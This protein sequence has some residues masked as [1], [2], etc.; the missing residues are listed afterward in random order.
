[1]IVSAF[2]SLVWQAAGG[3]PEWLTVI[4]VLILMLILVLIATVAF[5]RWQ[6]R[7][8]L[9]RRLVE[10]TRLAEA[11]KALAGAEL[12]S[13]RLAEL[14]YQQTAQIVDASSFQLGLFEGDRYRILIWVVDGQ[15]RPAAEYSLTTDNL[16][17][18]GWLRDNRRN[19]LVRDFQ[20]EAA[21]L[22]AQ[23]SYESADPPRS[24]V[25]VPL[26]SRGC[27]LGAVAIQSRQPNAF[28]EEDVRLLAIVA[29]QAASA[30]EN[31]QLLA[32]AQRRANQ[33]EL[34]AGVSQRIN[35]LQP[36]SALYKQIVDLVAS[37]F[38]EYAVSYYESQGETL[39]LCVSSPGPGEGPQPLER[40]P[41][42]EGAAGR[43]AQERRAVA[44]PNA[45]APGSQA[46]ETG[47]SSPQLAV[48]VEIDDR[49][50]GVLLVRGPANTVFDDSAQTVFGALA[51]QMAIAILEAQFYAAEQQR[52]DQLGALAQ[53]S[54]TVASSLELDD[55]LDEVLDVL[56]EHF[57]YKSIRIFLLYEDRLV[58]QAGIG[59]GTVGQAVGGLSYPLDGPGL[60][61]LV[62]RSRQP[63]L[64]D[65]VS[66]HPEYVPG[67]GLTST[68]S[69][70]AAP[71]NMGSRL[72]GVLDVQSDRVGAFGPEDAR[73]L[74]ALGD[75]LAVAVRNA[76]LFEYERRRRRLA[77]S[78]RDVSAALTSTL[79]LDHV[80]DLIL[81][82]LALVVSYDASSIL[83]VNDADEMILRASRGAS[84]AEEAIGTAMALK[85]YEPGE[86]VPSV[87]PFRDVDIAH[88]YHDLLSLPEP[89][90]CLAAALAPGGE[91]LGYLVVDKGGQ[92][93]FPQG[94]VELISTFASQ[95]AVAIENA[96]LYT[97][98]REQAWISTALLQVADAT[99]RST[100]LD[101]VL[102]TVARLT[103]LLVGVERCVVL[104]AEDMGWRLAA[105]A[106]ADDSPNLDP[107]QTL[108]QALA[109]EGW[110]RLAELREAREPLVLDPDETMPAGLREWFTGVVILLPLLARGQVAGAI[111]VGQVTGDSPFTAHRIQL[112]TGIA[113]Q[114]ALA[115]EGA[116]LSA[117]QQEEA[118]VSTALLQVAQSV[119]GQPLEIGLET[120][121]RLTPILVGVERV[122]IY[123]Y[124]RV[125]GGFRL[126][127][128][129]GLDREA[130]ARLQGRTIVLADLGLTRDDSLFGSP[131]PWSITLPA[132]L[133]SLFGRNQ[134]GVWPLRARGDTI[135]PG[136]ILG[137]LVT[138]AVPQLGRRQT[139][140]DGIAH[141]LAMALENDRLAY[142]VAQQ[143]RLERELEVGRDIQASLL[144][145][146]YPEA[147]G[148]E[149]A[150][151]WRA[152]RQV[153][154]D[155][156]DFFEL[157]PEQANP[158]WGVVIADVAD[159]G[160]PAALFMALSRTL[161]RSV[162]I[163][164]SAP[165]DTLRRVNELILSDARS[166][167]FVTVAYGVLEPASGRYCYALGGHNPPV[168]VRAD[169]SA[170]IV[171][172]RGIALGVVDHVDYQE[173]EITLCPGDALLLY[174]DG[175]TEAIDLRQQ[176]FG[177]ERV[178]AVARA[179]YQSTARDLLQA[180]TEAVDAHVGEAEVFDDMTI[181]VIKRALEAKE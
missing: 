117:A 137:V 132:P 70:M 78:M 3:R 32:Q 72:L 38:G 73:T 80:L 63:I 107:T 42:G 121:A 145:Q 98:Q 174:T 55:M 25:F 144:P 69:E 45:P 157:L 41:A 135:S 85:R 54:R 115:V 109:A 9:V 66:Q 79:Q 64:A 94:E 81:D 26:L 27:V 103:P 181:V 13:A 128:V 99:A 133:A 47:P 120:A 48:P 100:E 56:D 30:F 65:D 161:L 172:G 101:E 71:L 166:E 138:E 12:D 37:T 123:Q 156:Y 1:M 11:G 165:A 125:I 143:E 23:P 24:A 53:V 162:A 140:L 95:A 6:S 105:Q 91:H 102:D 155:F 40:V 114:A 175:L 31:A 168:W 113:N 163:G 170:A 126:R 141:Q 4:L 34:L 36:L 17:I 167:Q 50:R 92:S 29:N 7:Q 67:P 131:P 111:L 110:P 57:G 136:E 68:R 93:R 108:V 59:Q 77:E 106:T 160:V 118:W 152:A 82:G 44:L 51:A 158:R 159:K 5:R 153:G 151:L 119:A 16:G 83:L 130:T 177:L 104:M 116:L 176:E 10:L 18:M 171:P 148:W 87:Q 74:Q 178:L 150:A 142:E 122:A 76:R 96:R 139:I 58:Y 33:L 90:A 146:K 8:D 20:R 28:D 14:V 60:I 129:T 49:V 89:H 52:G 134:V 62:G 88:Q 112:L 19:L 86:S 35:V 75:T 15:R 149:I 154:G 21:E 43:A 46:L 124:D 147:A 2:L 164:R 173:Q 84:V 61:T 180:L 127:Q 179:N 169:G 97:A 39:V 22:P